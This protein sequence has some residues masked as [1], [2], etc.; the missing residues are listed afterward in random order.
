[1]HYMLLFK[2]KACS[3]DF[4]LLNFKP[5]FLFSLQFSISSHEVANKFDNLDFDKS[6]KAF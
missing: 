2:S 4:N 5:N 3:L 1:M 6:G